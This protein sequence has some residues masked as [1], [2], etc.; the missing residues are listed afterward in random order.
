MKIVSLYPVN[1][2]LDAWTGVFL[3]VYPFFPNA[4][5]GNCKI[6]SC[7]S[8]KCAWVFMVVLISW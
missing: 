2:K 3:L 1:V 4:S 7:N 6:D 5:D 8:E